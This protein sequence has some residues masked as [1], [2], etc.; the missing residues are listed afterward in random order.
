M[1]TWVSI[2]RKSYKGIQLMGFVVKKGNFCVPGSYFLEI[3]IFLINIYV[4]MGIN[5]SQ[6]L[7]LDR[8]KVFDNLYQPNLVTSKLFLEISIFQKCSLKSKISINMGINRT[9]IVMQ[10]EINTFHRLLNFQNL[11][12]K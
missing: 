6:I 4:N 5:R 11:S 7:M 1:L 2:D 8:I 9:K 3:S 12:T 10:N